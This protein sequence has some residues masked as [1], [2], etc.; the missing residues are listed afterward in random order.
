MPVSKTPAKR[1]RSLR[2][3]KPSLMTALW[4]VISLMFTI[5]FL[6]IQGTLMLILM[7]V[8]LL[9]TTLSA[10]ADFAADDSAVPAPKPRKAGSST[11]RGNTASTKKRPATSR[12]RTCSARC[13]NSTK[14][15]STCRCVCAGRT[16]GKRGASTSAPAKPSQPVGE[17]LKRVV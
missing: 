8:T 3:R 1:G 6:L 13:K 17:P 4:A 2:L 9:V 15:V 7:V 12:K 14:D 10:F 5:S 11:T 16:H